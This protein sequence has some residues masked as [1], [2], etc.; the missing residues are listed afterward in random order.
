MVAMGS[1]TD[2]MAGG[3]LNILGGNGDGSTEYEAPCAGLPFM[4]TFMLAVLSTIMVLQIE[5][6]ADAGPSAC[7]DAILAL[8]KACQAMT[9]HRTSTVAITGDQ[10]T[11]DRIF[12]PA[13]PLMQGKEILAQYLY[14]DLTCVIGPASLDSGPPCRRRFQAS[15]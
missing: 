2:I 6:Q 11:L 8:R 10:L 5:Q 13:L 9:G 14:I 12:R 15:V 7:G 3:L 1:Q 4:D